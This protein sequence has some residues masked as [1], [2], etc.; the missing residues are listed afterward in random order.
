MQ[1]QP[2]FASHNATIAVILV[3]LFYSQD[4]PKPSQIIFKIFHT[5]R[6]WAAVVSCGHH[7]VVQV[8]YSKVK[9]TVLNNLQ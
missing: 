7:M 5:K 3:N 8:A 2:S 6:I 1:F 4:L 9:L